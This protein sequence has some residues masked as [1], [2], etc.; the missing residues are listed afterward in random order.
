MTWIMNMNFL[1]KPHNTAFISMLQV[2]NPFPYIGNVATHL[3]YQIFS[4]PNFPAVV[5]TSL[6]Y[7][8]N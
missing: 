2:C 6:T 7:S 1:S 5:H 8:V 4:I 3:A